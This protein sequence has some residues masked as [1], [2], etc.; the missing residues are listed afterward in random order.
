MSRIGKELL[1]LAFFVSLA[2]AYSALDV[3]GSVSGMVTSFSEAHPELQEGSFYLE[4]SG[5]NLIT[6]QQ[7]AGSDGPIA[8]RKPVATGELVYCR[9]A[10]P[11]GEQTYI[12]YK[13][14][15][16]ACSSAL[17][18]ESETLKVGQTW[19]GKRIDSVQPTKVGIYNAIVLGLSAPVAPAAK[20]KC[21]ETD[22]SRVSGE[23]LV[24][25]IGN[26]EPLQGRE[27]CDFWSSCYKVA[28]SPQ[29][30]AAAN[31]YLCDVSGSLE[32]RETS[33]PGPYGL[34]IRGGPYSAAACEQARVAVQRQQQAQARPSQ[35]A[36]PAAAAKQLFAC[37]V[38]DASGE[39]FYKCVDNIRD[40]TQIPERRF[41]ESDRQKCETAAADLNVRKGYAARQPDVFLC[42][43]GETYSCE[44]DTRSC[45]DFRR[46]TRDQCS[47]EAATLNQ[48]A[49]K[50][51]LCYNERYSPQF[52]CEPRC[53]G[54]GTVAIA[55]SENIE[56]SACQAE[57]GRRIA[58]SERF[59]NLCLN[60]ETGVF[61][62]SDTACD[63]ASDVIEAGI[64]RK[65]CDRKARELASKGTRPPASQQAQAQYWLCKS[66]LGTASAVCTNTCSA[67]DRLRGPYLTPRQC[68]D[69][70]AILSRP[71]AP[72]A[73]T[74]PA[75]PAAG[76]SAEGERPPGRLPTTSGAT[77]ATPAAPGAP[78]A[79]AAQAEQ[80]LFACIPKDA[81]ETGDYSFECVGAEE[82][83]S[84][85]EKP[86]TFAGKDAKDN[87]ARTARSLNTPGELA[88]RRQQAVP[89]PAAA[90]PESPPGL[91]GMQGSA[92]AQYGVTPS[93]QAPTSPATPPAAA[94]ATWTLC[95]WQYESTNWDDNTIETYRGDYCTESTVCNN[96]EGHT[97]KGRGLTEQ[98]CYAKE[99][100]VLTA[101]RRI[102][103]PASAARPVPSAPAT[104][105]PP[106][107]VAPPGTVAA[108]AGVTGVGAAALKDF[109][110]CKYS[111]G[112]KMYFY[113]TEGRICPEGDSRAI[114]YI[115]QGESRAA[116][117]CD[118]DSDYLT[119][120]ALPEPIGEPFGAPFAGA[121]A[122]A[123]ATPEPEPLVLEQCTKYESAGY[124]C[125]GFGACDESAGDYIDNYLQCGAGTVC[126]YK[127]SGTTPPAA[128]PPTA[129]PAPAAEDVYV[130][131]KAVDN[132]YSPPLE[133]EY[134]AYGSC[135]EGTGDT[136]AGR[137]S[138]FIC[139]TPA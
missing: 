114:D 2:V 38:W 32:C 129:P 76:A 31:Y 10:C 106:R 24:I 60:K 132:S 25:A 94:A 102:G 14:T 79:P 40:C 34:S 8:C 100:N 22:S 62:C 66:Y 98:G 131:C 43:K 13:T 105:S 21:W 68:N 39:S 46:S 77:P 51:T 120:S 30:A 1:V 89:A 45:D 16:V 72:A 133:F 126:C 93:A 80:K 17:L 28:G 138:D 95:T 56:K 92:A 107:P 64:Q 84:E 73:A 49:S 83:C 3:K 55:G 26:R 99:T 134:C 35:P 124:K 130:L 61:S 19:F 125:V 90:Q 50:A 59:S 15:A 11:A 103:E 69:E 128:Q 5:D 82:F 108:G 23:C 7:V 67:T 58:A 137:F 53:T 122:S 97:A 42:K 37:L 47:A 75:A 33:C 87:C 104:P 41:A 118:S 117:T 36:A 86:R 27:G 6:G 4:S 96:Q 85:L 78:A 101:T 119:Q 70:Y 20:L 29:P 12:D 52:Y 135:V 115:Y 9:S 111:I 88:R 71:S 48:I 44:T 65:D 123:Q 113:C 109:I 136:P 54:L 112:A 57:A 18:T 139:T 91:S 81:V 74:P 63:T 116:T 127:A 121:Q 110:I